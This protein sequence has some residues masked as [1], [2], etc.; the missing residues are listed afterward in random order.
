MNFL[1]RFF[2]RD[3]ASSSNNG[4]VIGETYLVVGLG[5]PGREYAANRHNIGF[6]A[7][8][9]LA[10]AHHT[11]TGRF[12]DKA[13]TGDFRLGEHKIILVKPQTFMNNSGDAVG[14]LSKFY[15]VA[16]EKVI[17]VY[18]ELDLE[19][20]VVR[21]R[22]KGS[23]GGHNGMKSIINHIGSDFPRIRLGIGRPQGK[24]PVIAHVLQDFSKQDVEIVDLML[25]RTISA[26]ET[27]VRDGVTLSMSR[28]NGS[29]ISNSL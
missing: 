23:A 5:N 13:M 9:R 28:H 17:V 4:S 21:V 12:K 8:D 18:D 26:I 6:M 19:F 20:G 3:D 25:D 24:M 11:Q 22:E 10:Q 7:I 1:D 29:V 2:S 15:K 27:I 16:P 14:P